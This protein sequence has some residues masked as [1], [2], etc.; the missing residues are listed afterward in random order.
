[1]SLDSPGGQAGEV[2]YQPDAH[3]LAFGIIEELAQQLSDGTLDLP[4]LPEIVIQVRNLLDRD[5]CS[6]AQV[7]QLISSEPILAGALLRYA[8]SALYRRGGAE[9]GSLVT[10]IAR[11]GLQLVRRVCIEFSLQQ[12]RNAQAFRDKQV[13]L[14]PEWARGR[15]VAA[16]CHALARH[17]RRA[18]PDEMLTVGLVHN[19]GRI[20]MLSCD[21]VL[22]SLDK[23]GQ[24]LVDEWHPAVGRAIAEYWALPQAAVRAI[25]EQNAAADNAV[26]TA[27]AAEETQAVSDLLQLALVIA[28]SDL[29]GDFDPASV[30]E[31]PAAQR[32]GADARLLAAAHDEAEG[33]D[34]LLAA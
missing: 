6:T 9:T 5:D 1:M 12:L 19:I 26:D 33:M 28:T 15:S 29:I 30:A 10:A 8:N 16:L 4:S 32:L 2:L 3:T 7:A 34:E 17:T 25:G 11:L 13:L 24:G 23:A 18:Q 27:H 21:D 31:S 22:A 14:A 20:Y